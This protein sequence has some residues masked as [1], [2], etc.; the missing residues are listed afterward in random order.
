MSSEESQR[1][2][3]ALAQGGA[4]EREAAYASIEAAVRA[5]PPS[6]AAREQTVAFAV[7]CVKPLVTA[8]LSAPAT[9]IAR[10]ESTRATLLLYEM[11]KVDMIAVMGEANRKDEHGVS[12]YLNTWASPDNAFAV[13]LAKEPS[14]WTRDDALLASAVTGVWHS[15]VW[16]AG[17]TAVCA[18]AGLQESEWLGQ[19]A[20]ANP[21]GDTRMGESRQPE[22]RYVPLAL[23]CLDIVRS[24]MDTQPESVIACA[25]MTLCVVAG[26]GSL[27]PP[28]GKALWEAGFLDVF[29]ASLRRY[30]PIERISKHDLIASGVLSAFKDVVEGAQTAGLEVVQPL[31]DAGALDL[32]ISTLTAYQMLDNP[33]EASVCAV[34]YGALFGLEILLASPEA[35]PVAAKLRSAG[36]D[37]VRYMIDHPL[38]QVK[39]FGMGTGQSTTRIAALV[40]GRDDD[41]GGMRF[42]Q[43]DIDKVVQVTGHRHI[44]SNF[45]PLVVGYGKTVLSLR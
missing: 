22:D 27:A 20:P 43:Q 45:Y 25:A 9:K 44:T 1:I 28:V 41:G 32:A 4:E 39:D 30:N 37:S 42:R 38:D 23:L 24:E 40:W 5:A 18:A 31:V 29:Q 6:G 17:G 3:S 26:A 16:S 12:L 36:L 2:A 35:K 33:D 7:A 34:W 15:V 8:V 21:F 14:E 11:C 10:A 19:W 13:M